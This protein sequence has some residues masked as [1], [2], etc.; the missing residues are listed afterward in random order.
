MYGVM[1]S[2]VVS[3]TSGL[4]S[5]PSTPAKELILK[6]PGAKKIIWVENNN[7]VIFESGGVNYHGWFI[8]H[9]CNNINSMRYERDKCLSCNTIIPPKV[10]ALCQLLNIDDKRL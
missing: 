7:W 8:R 1:A 10:K 9:P 6:I 5:N 4:G 3:K 2:M